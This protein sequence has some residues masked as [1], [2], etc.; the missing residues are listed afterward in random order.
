M[1][2]MIEVRPDVTEREQIWHMKEQLEVYLNTIESRLK[3]MDDIYPVGS[4]YMSVNSTDPGT[5]FGGT[6]TRLTDTFLLAAGSTYAAGGTGGA[7]TVTL[8]TTQIPAHTHG[9]KTLTGSAY[10]RKWYSGNEIV[11]A[12]GIVRRSNLTYSANSNGESGINPN[13]VDVLT[14]DATHTHDSVGGSKAHNNMP[15]YLAVYC[16]KRI[17]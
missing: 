4:I 7:A 1:S 15:P 8:D 2:V 9:S 10:F 17:A 12:S 13:A 3:S 16:W 14:V 11:T 5:L 6:W